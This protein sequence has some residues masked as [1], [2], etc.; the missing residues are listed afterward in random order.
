MKTPTLSV[1]VLLLAAS[2]AFADRR[3]LSVDVSGE[4]TAGAVSALQTAQPQSTLS[5]GPGV[6]LGAR[7]GLTNSFE[8][9]ATGLFETPVTVAHNG[10]VLVTDAGS[11]AGTL[12]HSTMRAGGM[13]GA[14]AVFGMTWRFH[15]GLE[16]G[17]S[18]RFYSGLKMYDDS[19][20]DG[21]IDYGLTLHDTTQG[22]LLVSPVVG[23]EWAAGDHWSLS[24]LPRAQL[25]LL[26]KQTT[27]T[28]MVPLQFSWSWFL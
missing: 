15:V 25:L 22:Q 27:W 20:P 1:V 10:V 11:F 8:L 24:V 2:P 23:L 6:L 16:V 5:L 12:V 4:W 9:T 28:V 7:Y 19:N 21:A 13:V 26:G 3:A 14:R 18:Q 17:W